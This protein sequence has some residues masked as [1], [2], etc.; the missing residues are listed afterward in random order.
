MQDDPIQL[1]QDDMTFTV[2]T[3]ASDGEIVRLRSKGKIAELL[4]LQFR[5]LNTKKPRA[6][7]VASI[8]LNDGINGLKRLRKSIDNTINNFENHEP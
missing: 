7:V 5:T 4:V 2:P 1:N 8:R 6:D 3:V